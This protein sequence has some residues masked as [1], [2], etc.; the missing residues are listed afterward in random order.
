[1]TYSKKYDLAVIGSG[2]GGYVAA[3]K[4]SQSGAKVALIEKGLLG[5][6][7]LN[8]GCIPTKSLLSNAS[9]LQKIRKASEFGIEVGNV[10][11]DYK[12]MKVRK[13]G[14]VDKMRKSLE[15]LILS[16]GIEILRGSAS[17]VNQ[18]EIK[19]KG[20]DNIH[21]Y[22]EKVIIA[23]GSE[24]LEIFPCDH[25]KIFNSS[26]ILDLEVL[27]KSI[28]IIGGGYIGCEF[29]SLFAELGVSVTILEALPSIVSLQGKSISETLT[30]AF[31]KKGIQ[32]KT[33]V[34][35]EKLT[36]HDKGVKATL[37]GAGEL[38]FDIALVAVGRKVV[39]QNLQIENAGVL[40]NERGV[41]SVDDKM[42]TSVPGIYAIGDVTGKVMLAHVASHQGIVAASNAT[43]QT[44]YM[45]YEAVPA[46]IFTFPEIACVGLTVEQA[47]EK[48]YSVSVGKFPFL[49]LGKSVASND[50]EGYAQII[51]DTKTGQILGAEVVGYDASALIGEIALA[52]ANELTL[53]CVIETIHAHP[54][55]AE[56]W[57]EAA[58]LANGTP[59]HLPPKQ[60]KT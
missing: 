26:S 35:V 5:G 31:T 43:G 8:V 13:D 59:I 34:M 53:D 55:T 47:E 27:P 24:P 38:D 28:A 32:I 1:M 40:V 25:K 44:A 50:V 18:H 30:R 7:C 11:F 41:I 2:P 3:I 10:S 19:V 23:T 16:N 33:G 17:F 60:K 46:V 49:A 39:S 51:S 54:T 57:H 29:A 21:L 56:G 9:L 22:A 12:K 14:V 36:A 15:G 37:K 6:V 42:E 48:G 4:A 52:I 45:H 20:Q 58:L